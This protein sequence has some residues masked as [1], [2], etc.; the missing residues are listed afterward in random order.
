MG[1]GFFRREVEVDRA[2]GEISG[3]EDRI[4]VGI[5]V[6][7]GV[8]VLCCDGENQLTGPDGPG[9]FHLGGCTEGAADVGRI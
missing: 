3:R 2:F 8:E 9:V 1:Y 6:S 5:A 4:D 7:V